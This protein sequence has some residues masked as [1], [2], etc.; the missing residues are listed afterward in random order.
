M[1][2]SLKAI[3]Y[4]I[5]TI[6]ALLAVLS[7]VYR[8]WRNGI[9]PMPTSAPVR[10]VVASEVR[11]LQGASDAG[12]LVDAGSGW[13]TLAFQLDK[14]MSG[15]RIIGLE[16]SIVPLYASR[17]INRLRRSDQRVIFLRKNMYSCAFEF[18]QA[19]IIVCY[20]Y[21]G[22]MERLAHHWRSQCKPGAYIVSI[23]FALPGWKP[24]KELVCK[25]IYRTKIYVY[26]VGV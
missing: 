11:R 4:S 5:L 9:S 2:E 18:E 12:L 25:D 22:A 26:R 21:P 19:D 14:P 16:N 6:T 17:L 7:I 1:L 24:E 10:R 13:G 8:S 23:C 15:W 20:L 3:L